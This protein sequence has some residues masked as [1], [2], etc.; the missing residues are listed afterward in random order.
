[1]AEGMLSLSWNN[2]SVTFCHSL[3]SL[4]AKERYTDVTL[5][6]EGRFYSVHK[7]VLST[8]SDYFENIFEHTPCKHPVIVLRDVKCDELEALLSYMYAGVVSVAQTDLPRLIKVAEL[9]QIKGLAVPDEPP[10]SSGVSPSVQKSSSDR[11]SPYAARRHSQGSTN[12][13]NSPNPRSKSAHSHSDGV[14]PQPKRMRSEGDNTML[15]DRLIAP[16]VSPAQG[17]DSSHSPVVEWSSEPGR[18]LTGEQELENTEDI[19]SKAES[20]SQD[21]GCEIQIKEEVMDDMRG[22]DAS[23]SDSG[24]DYTSM[25]SDV[26]LS[27]GDQGLSSGH[28][29]DHIDASS[30]MMM[31]LEHSNTSQQPGIRSL[32]RAEAYAEGMNT[33]MPGPSELQGWFGG[34]AMTGLSMV[35]GNMGDDGQLYSQDISQQH[36]E[37]VPQTPNRG[38]AS[39]KRHQC[40]F[41]NYSTALKIDLTKHIRIHTGERPYACP[42]CSARFTQKESLKPH[43]RT[44]T[45]EKPYACFRCPY[46][47][48]RKS[49]LR[50]HVFSRHNA[51][52]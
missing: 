23:I 14:S 39:S 26:V 7:L 2:H 40:T 42:Y 50:S 6:C 35:K 4:R 18:S 28:R 41:C 37:R 48:T 51:G 30:L 34:E 31:K 16:S 46:R 33:T 3:I 12:V 38:E 29:S 20:S 22:G 17:K 24:L 1:M 9:F 45:G 36:R 44:H 19:D 8:C 47:A 52:D 15:Q 27:R 25:S 5:T 32:I 43:I 13:R 49:S 11:N 10:K 21:A